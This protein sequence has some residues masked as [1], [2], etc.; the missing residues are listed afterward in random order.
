[1]AAVINNDYQTNLLFKR[2]TGVA[3]TQ[4]D[5]E[6]S[7]EPYRA[8][9]NIFSRD[10]LIEEVPEQAP[11]SILILDNS[12]NWHDSS[13]GNPSLD[14][15]GKTFAD[16]YPDSH[17]QFYKNVALTAV[18][19][20][21]NRVWRKLDNLG[22][23][24]L[25]DTLNFKYDDVNS[26]YLMR[27]K[28]QPNSVYIN[29]TINSFP[30]FWVFDSE[31]GFLQM[32]QTQTLLESVS[33]VHIN[34]PKISYF[35]YVGKKGLLNLDISGQA[36]V[37]D[38]SGQSRDL[39][40]IQ[41][42]IDNI[43][44]MILPDGY[45]DI[46]GGAPFDLSG[47]EVVRTYFNYIRTNAF[48][49]Y[50]NLP[51]VDGSGVVL[52]ADDPS[53]NGIIYELD[54]SG[55][56]Y[57]S[58]NL[59][60]KGNSQMEDV[61]ANNMD[62]SG[63]LT[64][65]GGDEIASFY[66]NASSGIQFYRDISMNMRQI[67]NIRD[68][69][70]PSG[71]PSLGQ[72]NSIMNASGSHWVANLNHIYY[73][74]VG[75]VGIN[76]NLPTAALDV[77]GAA[78][79]SEDMKIAHHANLSGIAADKNLYVRNANLVDSVKI[80]SSTFFTNYWTKM[81]D[82]E[83]QNLSHPYV[84]TF[85]PCLIP[86]ATIDINQTYSNYVPNQRP[87]IANCC[88]YF[89]IKFS[90]LPPQTGIANLNWATNDPSI[91]GPGKQTLFNVIPE[92]TI[93]FIAGY[94]D[95]YEDFA[96][97]G[98]NPKPF[99]KVLSTN[100]AELQH[101]NGNVDISIRNATNN[102][103]SY[104]GAAY[105]Q[106]GGFTRI[107]IAEGISHDP[108]IP[109]L[110]KNKAWLF[111]E[112][113]W[114]DYPFQ[115]ITLGYQNRID[116]Q[117]IIEHHI[118]DIK[119]Y[120]NNAGELRIGR[121]PNAHIQNTDWQLLTQNKIDAYS[122]DPKMFVL[123]GP[124]FPN[125]ANATPPV[126]GADVT[127]Q[128]GGQG[129]PIII[130]SP[131]LWSA[132]LNLHD[133]TYGINTCYEVI[134]GNMDVCG[135]LDA[136]RIISSTAQITN[137]DAT[138][139]NAANID[140]SNQVTIGSNIIIG[141]LN[142]TFT[143]IT[144]TGPLD[145]GT[146]IISCG[147]VHVN[148]GG[149]METPILQNRNSVLD[150][151]MG[152]ANSYEW[153]RLAKCNHK[154]N[155]DMKAL[156]NGFFELTFLYGSNTS[157]PYHII[158]FMVGS[159][160]AKAGSGGVKNIFINVLS[161]SCDAIS[162]VDW[163]FRKLALLVDN[164]NKIT[165][166]AQVKEN[167]TAKITMRIYQNNWDIKTPHDDHTNWSFIYTNNY[168]NSGNLPT[169]NINR[170]LI[171]DLTHEVPSNPTFGGGGAIDTAYVDSCGNSLY[172][173]SAIFST[174]IDFMQNCRF[175]RGIDV[176]NAKLMNVRA[177][178]GKDQT[179]IGNDQ[180]SAPN[181]TDLYIE[182]IVSGGMQFKV[183]PNSS[184]TFSGRDS[185]GIETS[186]IE[187]QTY[188]IGHIDMDF[189]NTNNLIN[190]LDLS[191]TNILTSS[192]SINGA[193]DAFT[194]LNMHD[195]Y[196]KNASFTTICTSSDNVGAGGIIIGKRRYTSNGEHTLLSLDC[197]NNIFGEFSFGYDGGGGG[198]AIKIVGAGGVNTTYMTNNTADPR[199]HPLT[200]Q[201]QVSGTG[202]SSKDN[203][204]FVRLNN[205][206]DINGGST[207]FLTKE[208]SDASGGNNL[209]TSI[210]TRVG[211]DAPYYAADNIPGGGSSNNKLPIFN[212]VSVGN[213]GPAGD[214]PRSALILSSVATKYNAEGLNVLGTY[215]NGVSTFD[216]Y[217]TGNTG[218][219]PRLTLQLGDPSYKP[220]VRI[221]GGHTINNFGGP[222]NTFRGGGVLSSHTILTRI[223]RNDIS[224]L[225][226][227]DNDL[228]LE[229]YYGDINLYNGIPGN[230]INIGT[231]VPTQINIGKYNAATEI[232]LNQPIK[233]DA[234]AN[235]IRIEDSLHLN[236]AA[237]GV[238]IYMNSGADI[239]VGSGTGTSHIFSSAHTGQI[240][241]FGFTNGTELKGEDLKVGGNVSC[242]NITCPLKFFILK[243]E[244]ATDGDHAPYIKY[245]NVE[246]PQGVV[247][248]RGQVI[249]T[250]MNKATINVDTAVA[251]HGTMLI[252]HTFPHSKIPPGTFKKMFQNATAWVC[253][254]GI[255]RSN[256]VD[257]ITA[258]LDHDPLYTRV[259]ALI[260]TTSSPDEVL[261][262]I[263]ADPAGNSSIV[264]NYRIEAERR[265]V[266]YQ[267]KDAE[268]FIQ[269]ASGKQLQL[270]A[271]EVKVMTG[272]NCQP[273]FNSYTGAD[274][275]YC[276]AALPSGNVF[277]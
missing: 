244:A 48:I 3:A 144:N 261:L 146:N 239:K 215:G 149:S 98:R 264:V 28:H 262:K 212:I 201:N 96:V 47:S 273:H 171:C 15:G 36:Q 154:T 150:L 76:N 80:P 207:L 183:K 126:I 163:N 188:T 68:A 185:G 274:K 101:L 232:Y 195:N 132:E 119:M 56:S 180:G 103:T 170:Q 66:H 246:A 70:D 143:G 10:I 97:E 130:S 219:W 159:A 153:Y 99:I 46:S 124:Q 175:Q 211:N 161:N 122:A 94:K 121:D 20:S 177:L 198:G 5:A 89:T 135:N 12:A 205:N 174:A 213:D 79:I 55:N 14:S 178:L 140:V 26:S 39:S 202:D 210:N 241:T 87:L 166:Y 253:N 145:N 7:N 196:I 22:K 168:D 265:D 179:I 38:I 229:S 83:Q 18:A 220:L 115:S 189:K 60:V 204:A 254:A 277:I 88:A 269:D 259:G 267:G 27:V 114:N 21:Q 139:I 84:S 71:V 218:I 62:V 240:G 72:V 50:Y 251:H 184:F 275:T 30:L 258:N 43:N 52:H 230:N 33:K 31:S 45:V 9:K 40:G 155:P 42:K 160:S 63:T 6:F 86:F 65:G 190:V 172:G 23:N 11:I 243:N 228:K 222:I 85:G 134:K 118:L 255:Y 32:H 164:D 141:P 108:N 245:C 81:I 200:F 75:N 133:W 41:F 128:I 268:I 13:G 102:Y 173:A 266:F 137:I 186:A 221:A 61:S 182:N 64:I 276:A 105:A 51:R 192:L 147:I 59:V 91:V 116:L 235:G 125:P 2:F 187:L 106:I 233:A 169:A 53:H 148:A 194:D 35:R 74:G 199:T 165:L 8:V 82:L 90:Q 203:I 158:R 242:S 217:L 151:G 127:L 19:G 156:C 247:I 152:T 181:N 226:V 54:V 249:L 112:Q 131:N 4:L 111:L 167:S 69:T 136:N 214:H 257:G 234:S 113:Q 142:S 256:G 208:T 176:D 216:N 37:S 237:G 67:N 250:A 109:A 92:Q 120:K 100:I 110:L 57:I 162:N 117:E 209:T 231:D 129:F 24:L 138:N 223:I 271:D 206:S 73:S 248:L 1:M 123:R 272:D 238:H 157:Q 49:G 107:V 104:P 78:N 95:N 191:A 236:N 197:S 260:D 25:Q 263:T 58:G 17:L 270:T 34:P 225:N 44:R 77:V 224:S 93:H 16:L 29:N 252:P 193:F 227:S